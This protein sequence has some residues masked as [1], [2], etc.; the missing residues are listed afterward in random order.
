MLST[1]KYGEEYQSVTPPIHRSSYS[2][3]CNMSDAATVN[4]DREDHILPVHAKFCG[5]GTDV[6]INLHFGDGSNDDIRRAEVLLLKGYNI[7][8]PEDHRIRWHKVGE[9][10]EPIRPYI[11]FQIEQRMA[12]KPKAYY[13]K[14]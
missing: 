10:H 6:A 2:R 1:Y 7:A 11:G 14:D 8:N 3:T 5:K 4:S 12:S 9:S 13:G